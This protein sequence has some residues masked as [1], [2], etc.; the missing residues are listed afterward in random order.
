MGFLKEEEKEKLREILRKGAD[1]E[2]KVIIDFT[3]KLHDAMPDGDSIKEWAE[4]QANA[5]NEARVE[6]TKR[7]TDLVNKK[8]GI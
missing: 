8:M 3:E 2:A 6:M 4:K 1:K 7:F 5:F